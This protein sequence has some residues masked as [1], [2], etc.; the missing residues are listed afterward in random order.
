V[1]SRLGRSAGLSGLAKRVGHDIASPILGSEGALPV[2]TVWT[3]R[4]GDN[5]W[6]RFDKLSLGR[7]GHA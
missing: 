3:E 2:A 5:L 4:S 6:K 1:G 7:Y